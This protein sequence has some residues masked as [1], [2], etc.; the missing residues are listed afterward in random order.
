MFALKHRLLVLVRTAS[1][2]VPTI[3]VLRNNKKKIQTFELKIVSFTT[4]NI[5][6]TLARTCLRNGSGLSS[7]ERVQF[8]V[9]EYPASVPGPGTFF[10]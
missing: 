10:H 4:I 1:M 7:W 5:H 3:C 9:W 2:I 8:S 6:S